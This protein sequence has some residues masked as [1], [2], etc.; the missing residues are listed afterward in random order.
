MAL[1]Q[2]G[3]TLS[4]IIVPILVLG[5]LILVHEFGHFL[6]AK[7][8]GV[9][10]LKFSIGFGPSLL[11]FRRG[12]TEY[13]V[14][15]IPLG[16]YV[17][18]VGDMPDMITGPQETDEEVRA[19][20]QQTTPGGDRS[21]WFIEKGLI[22]KS[23]IVFAGPL[24]N[25]L[26]AIVLLFIGV[27]TF[28][29]PYLVEEPVIGA[30]QENSPAQKAGLLK[31]DLVLAIDNVSL[32][33]WEKLAQ[34]VH[35]GT[36]DTITLHVDRD[37]KQLTLPVLPLKKEARMINGDTKNAFFI[38]VE[39]MLAHREVPLDR[40]V[41]ISFLETYQRTIDTAEGIW[42]ML[43]GKIS[44]EEIAGPI[45]IFQEANRQKEQG[46]EY[47]I[48]FMVWLSV[49]LAVLNLLPIPVL[50]GG[51]LL[52]FFLEALFG[53]ISIKKRELAQQFGV[54]LLLGL[55]ILA[56]RNDFVRD[57]GKGKI[58]WQETEKKP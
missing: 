58:E 20:D 53:P 30:V 1:D 36:G 41:T 50:D 5:I 6:F 9:G 7:L 56:I 57:H 35:N 55:M 34:T 39:P 16:G 54:L 46:I 2:I 25:F 49:S 18:M 29:E 22:A 24:F 44:P 31:G 15:L 33:S 43:A 21:N 52:F 4:I 17:R 38:G 42:R 23:L 19:I 8:F 40:A 3:S 28:G 51:H 26:L 45:F 13:T 10:V 47:L 14:S 27:I 11:R 32:D 12:E 48:N 37:G